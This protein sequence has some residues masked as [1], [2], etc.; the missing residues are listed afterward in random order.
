MRSVLPSASLLLTAFALVAAPFLAAPSVA[1]AQCVPG[2]VFCA[3]IHIGGPVYVPPPTP[4]VV[5]V[6]PAPPPVVYVQQPPPPPQVVYVQQ[7]A[8]QPPPPQV[9]YVQ[10]PAP[11]AGL[12]YPQQAP[13]APRYPRVGLHGH[14]GGIGGD[15]VSMGGMTGALRV[16]TSPAIA[17]EFGLGVYGGTDYN[18]DERV[19]VPLT[20]DAL[21]FVNPDNALQLYGLV[22]LGVSFAATGDHVFHDPG[23]HDEVYTSGEDHAYVGGQIGVGLELKLSDNLAINTDVRA[24]LRENVGNDADDSPEF[25]ET[26][27]SGRVTRSTNTSS[28]AMFTLG[29]TIYF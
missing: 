15:N 16:R 1:D 14:V 9:V 23:F 12:V 11:N 4:P 5:Y 29:G 21:F 27:G 22:G 25:V 17:F 8:P 7:P 26:D 13:A 10:Q 20:A 19:E 18:G 3:D 24:F 2:S 28:G 6:R